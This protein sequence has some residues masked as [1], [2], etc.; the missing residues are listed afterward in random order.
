MD[1]INSTL[2]NN[3]DSKAL[4]SLFKHGIEIFGT[5]Q[6]LVKWLESEN[7]F[8]DKKAPIEFLKTPEGMEYIDSRLTGLEYGDNA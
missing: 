8:F 7:F 6:N 2:S 5:E 4:A 1:T 3:V